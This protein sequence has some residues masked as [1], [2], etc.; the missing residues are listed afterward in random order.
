MQKLI[1]AIVLSCLLAVIGCASG[2]KKKDSGFFTSGSREADQRAEQRIA[3]DAQVASDK[4]DGNKSDAKPTLYERL[5]GESGLQAI[6]N[7]FVDRAIADPRVNW[8]RQN[9][10][11]GGVMGIGQRKVKTWDASAENLGS[12]KSH[13]AQ[14]L[15][16]ATGGPVKYDGKQMRDVHRGLQISN[17]EFDASIGDLKSTLDK[18]GVPTPEQKELIAI[19][20]STRQQ[21][22]EKR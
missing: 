5:G 21:I 19:V 22:V 8:Q 15:A 4:K 3:R 18:L 11:H 2:E 10:S 13:I 12:L 1:N 20:E 17:P 6:A 16:I 14:F 9:I 7:D